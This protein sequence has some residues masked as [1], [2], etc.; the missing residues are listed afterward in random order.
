M[1]V[2]LYIRLVGFYDIST[3]VDYSMPNIDYLYLY[4]T[5]A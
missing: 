2:H 3:F 4:Q 5:L 1:C